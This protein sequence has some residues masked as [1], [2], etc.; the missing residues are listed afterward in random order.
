MLQGTVLAL[1]LAAWAIATIVLV[2][3]GWRSLASRF[4]HR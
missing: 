1:G 2:G 3:E 4:R